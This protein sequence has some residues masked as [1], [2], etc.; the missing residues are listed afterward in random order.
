[1]RDRASVSAPEINIT[2]GADRGPRRHPRPGRELRRHQGRVRDARAVHR[3][4]GRGRPADLEHLGVRRH[5]ATRCAAS[6]PSDTVE[7]E[8]HDIMPHYLPDGRIVF[9]STRQRQ[10]RA[11]LLDENKPQYAA[12]DEDDQRAGVRAARDGRRRHEHPPDLV[13]PEPRSRPGGAAERA[14]RVHAL[15]TSH[16]RQPVRSLQRQPGRHRSA[17]AVR[18][19]QPRD[20]HGRSG[21]ERAEHHSVPEP[22]PDAGRPHAGAGAPVLR[23]RRRRRPGA[24]RHAELRRQHRARRA[25]LRHAAVPRRCARCRPTCARS[26]VRRPAAVTARRR[27]CSTAAIACW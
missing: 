26:K 27:R 18:R 10:S 3:R 22:A 2:A 13:Q 1:M 11:I 12:Q 21:H 24:D 14:H 19:E 25:E 9:S 15:G 23:H 7:D 4:R 6:S 5:D 8:G 16:R 20:R 17:A